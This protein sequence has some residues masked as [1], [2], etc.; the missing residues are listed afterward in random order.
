MK[1]GRHQNRDGR[2][3]REAHVSPGMRGDASTNTVATSMS[4]HGITASTTN[5]AVKGDCGL[6]TGVWPQWPR[7]LSIWANIL[8][9]CA[10]NN[11]VM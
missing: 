2:E 5:P 8:E 10:Y 11:D 3:E 6:G 4:A 7:P 9:L 1:V